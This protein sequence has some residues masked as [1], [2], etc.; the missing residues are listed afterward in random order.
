MTK[1]WQQHYLS[2]WGRM[3]LAGIAALVLLTGCGGGGGGG[4]GGGASQPQSVTVTGT[5]KDKSTSNVLP[6]RTITVQNTSL[7]GT[8]N[9]SGVFSISS[10]PVGTITLVVKDSNGTSDGSSSAI[11]LSNFSGDPRNVGTIVLDVNGT[12]PPKPPGG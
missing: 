2:A 5:L 12:G 9:S 3:A 8:S 6:N 11:N 10:V 7:T 4:G 1:G